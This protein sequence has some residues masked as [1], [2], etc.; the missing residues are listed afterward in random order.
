MSLGLLVISAPACCGKWVMC[1]QLLGRLELFTVLVILNPVSW[2][3][4]ANEAFAGTNFNLCLLIDQIDRF[5]HHLIVISRSLGVD[6]SFT[7]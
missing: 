7:D 4:G 2:P 3:L 6:V 5:Y 1:W